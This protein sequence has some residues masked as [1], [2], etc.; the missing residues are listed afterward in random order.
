M[1]IIYS[2]EACFVKNFQYRTFKKQD[3]FASKLSRDQGL[4]VCDVQE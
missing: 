1:K 4:Y 2:I 3:C